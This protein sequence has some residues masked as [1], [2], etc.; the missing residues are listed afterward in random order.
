MAKTLFSMVLGAHGRWFH[1]VSYSLPHPS[2]T[3]GHCPWKFPLLDDRNRG[4]PWQ[5][6][7]GRSMIA[8]PT[9]GFFPKLGIAYIQRGDCLQGKNKYA[10]PLFKERFLS[11]FGMYFFPT[12]CLKRV[13]SWLYT[14]R[15]WRHSSFKWLF[16]MT[17][18]IHRSFAEE[19]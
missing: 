10:L 4:G 14:Y 7:S 18:K 15:I 11:N 9:V 8:W 13:W 19:S 1:Q 6:C 2:D 12:S 17:I 5:W 16:P 3:G